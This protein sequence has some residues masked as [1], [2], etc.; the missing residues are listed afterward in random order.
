LSDSAPSDIQIQPP[1]N[2]YICTAPRNPNDSQFWSY[3]ASSSINSESS[4]VETP[5]SHS[6]TDQTSTFTSTEDQILDSSSANSGNVSFE[7][8]STLFNTITNNT[9]VEFCERLPSDTDSISN[10]SIQNN[11]YS[12]L[13]KRKVIDDE[14]LTRPSDETIKKPKYDDDID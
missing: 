10:I 12:Y 5:L 8:S 14:N 13:G 1:Y 2:P 3:E 9:R 11:S 6:S 7:S 4:S